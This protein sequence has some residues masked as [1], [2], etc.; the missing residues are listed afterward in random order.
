M[1]QKSETDQLSSAHE[2]WM[3]EESRI[4]SGTALSTLGSYGRGAED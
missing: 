2:I 3:G 4:R 1:K